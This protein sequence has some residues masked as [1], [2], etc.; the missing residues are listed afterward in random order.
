[1]AVSREEMQSLYDEG[2]TLQQIAEQYGVS[3]QRIGQI[4]GPQRKNAHNGGRRRAALLEERR[5][6]FDRIISGE[7]T[8]KIEA[9]DLGLTPD[10]LRGYF[11]ANGLHIPTQYELSPKHGTVYRYQR[12]CRCAQCKKAQRALRA[13]RKGREPPTHGHSGYTNFACRCDICRAAG[14]KA[15]REARE[16]RPRRQEESGERPRRDH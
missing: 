11:D 3:R 1:M 6:A 7:S 12:G 10:Y 5:P 16:K 15:N 8:L 2:Y 14:S 9:D 13:A 4:I